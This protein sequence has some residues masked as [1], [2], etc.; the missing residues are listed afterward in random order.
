MNRVLRQLFGGLLVVLLAS[1][2]AF[3]QGATAQ[4][5]GT[6][7]DDSGGVLPGADVTAI[8]TD[9]GFRRTVITDEA[10]AYTL[11]QL[12]I[13]PYRLEVALQGF[14]SFQQTGIVLQID[15][16]PVINVTLPLGQLSETVSVEASAPLVE[17]RN[18]SI[19]QVIENE[20]IEE[21]P[22]NGRNA[23][24]LVTL[25]GAA[26]RPEG[27]GGVSSS[28]SMQGGLGISVAGGQVFG[29]TYLLDGAI[30]NN[31]YDN[32]NLPLPFPDALQEFRVETS[33]QNAQNGFHAGASVNLAT[34]SGTNLYHGDLFEFVR[35]HRFN[36]TNPFNAVDPATGERRDDGLKRNQFGGT[37]GG[38]LK[39]DRLFF[40]GAYQGT[41]T[42]E[43]P[44]DDVRF[45][46]TAAMLAGD[47]TAAA[48][49]PCVT[50]AA[51]TLGAPFVGNRVDPALFSP[52]ALRIAR[53]LPTTTDPCGRTSVTNPRNIDEKQMIGKVDFQV[54]QNHS[55]FGR[56]MAT[57]FFYA[58]PFEQSQ[59]ILSTRLG[60]RDNLAQSV[61][62]GDTMVLSNN[63]VNNIRVA[64]NRTAIHRTHTNFFDPSDVG[65]NSFSY[66]P[67]YMLLTITGGFNLGGGTESDAVFNTNT[68]TIADDLTMIRG[69]HQY[70]FGASYVYWDSLSAANVRSPGTFTFDGGATGLGL[71]DFL[72][73]RPFTFIQS[74]PNTLD[75]HQHYIGFY[76]QDTWKLSP[77][78]TVNYGVRWEPWFPQQQDNGAV[79]NFSPDRFRA[80]QRS[81]VFPQAP[82]GFTYPGDEGFN[83][84]AGMR[85]DWWNFA[86][87][88]GVAWD[89]RGDGRMSVRAG[90]GM[91]G[92]FVNGQ[93]FINAANAPP[94]GSELRL[95]RPLI[96][97]FDD[98]FRATGVANPFPVTFDANAPF[99]LNGP[100]VATPTDLDTTRVHAWNVSAQRQIG[101]DLAV[102][103]SYIGNYTTNLWDVVTGNPGVV[104]GSGPCTLNSAT[105]PQ[106]FPNCNNAPLDLRRELSLSNYSVGRFIG[107]L[108]YFTDFGY[109]KYNG[110]LLSVQ[111]RAANGINASANYTLS[112]CDGHPTQGGGTS[113]VAS[114]YMIPV[115]IFTPPSEEE[116]E[117]RLDADYG[118][119]DNDRRHIFNATVTAETP[120]FDNATTRMLASGWRVSGIF[121]AMSGRALTITTGLDRALVGNPNQQRAN[122]VLDDP[123]GD[124]TWNSW[125]NP[126]A[127]AQPAIGEFGNSVR[128]GYVGRG[129]RVV[130]LSLVRSFRFGDTHRIEA[131]IEAF[132]AFNWFRPG[133]SGNTAVTDAPV[134]NLNNANFGRY[135][136]ADDPRIMQ[137]ALKYQF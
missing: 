39:T 86:P 104:L 21:L 133:P 47:F 80:G 78:M 107:F 60:G 135:L 73:G 83:G 1:N 114:G 106:T 59:N 98:P 46:P 124:G 65:I 128:N 64:F 91:N 30:H 126:A 43:R 127:F 14:R 90:Y 19:G 12:P 4:I 70:G 35:H 16:N 17:T 18:P 105:G 109:Q 108:D 121:R 120:Q 51:R 13:G 97:P 137:F 7:R 52:A 2:V 33:S 55:I 24:D 117:R 31:P 72:L 53:E 122:Q 116:R 45:V 54:S 112:K 41:K 49:P 50:G 44:S 118:P 42:D 37:F 9:T 81:T 66:L 10:G 27:A 8:Q 36:A 58:P 5:N 23:A 29:T 130:D 75:N 136:A 89:P 125:L 40:F 26:V 115:S 38:P 6:V 92:E 119:C 131:R 101:N 32:Y 22:L 85:A 61:T 71:S 77:T 100:Y 20:R 25:T 48:A 79:Y 15:A 94:W 3:G 123:Y 129:S 84:K 62:G 110:L 82:P 63:V 74:A 111:R 132:N 76:G 103:A 11:T 68:Y 113:N 102:S 87:R 56:Y 99:S 34:K 28:R 69:N 95:T 57:T 134:T 67:D 96:G 93:F 88:V